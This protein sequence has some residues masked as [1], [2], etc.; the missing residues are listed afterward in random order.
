[1]GFSS[2]VNIENTTL[3]SDGQLPT[4]HGAYAKPL[5]KLAFRAIEAAG[6]CPRRS[7]LVVE[8]R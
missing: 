3:P 7:R 2:R 1:M 4:C 5:T 8:H 6:Q